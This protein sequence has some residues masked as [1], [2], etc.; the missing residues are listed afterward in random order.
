MTDH[1]TIGAR[2]GQRLKVTADEIIAEVR[3]MP[4]SLI[5]WVPGEG[6]WSVMDNLC[7]IR[8]FVPFWTAEVLRIVGTPTELWGRDHTDAARLAAVTNTTAFTLAEVVNDIRSAVDTSVSTL[9]RL[10]DADL[11]TEAT[12]RNPRWGLKPASFVVEH[13]LVQHLEKHL[14][15]IR[16]NVAQYAALT[17]DQRHPSAP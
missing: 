1:P 17:G 3:R 15:Q 6:V 16:R 8:E 11:A 4:A 10:S 14:G 9:S 12:S 5:T 7:H 2:A 13:L